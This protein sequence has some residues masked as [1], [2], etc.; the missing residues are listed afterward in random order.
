MF[1]NYFIIKGTPENASYPLVQ[2]D[3]LS[4]P[5]PGEATSGAVLYSCTKERMGEKGHYQSN[6]TNN[7]A[8]YRGLL[9]G[10]EL[11]IRH[12]IQEVL[13]E[14]DSQLV[15]MQVAKKWK[16]KN[17]ELQVI[18]DKIQELIQAHFQFV[19]IRHIP[20]EQNNYAD[21]ITNRV[22]QQKQSYEWPEQ[23]IS[24]PVIVHVEEKKMEK[25][26][27]IPTVVGD[28]TLHQEVQILKQDML[29]LKTD[30]REILRLIHLVYDF[31]TQ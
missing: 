3:G 15:V 22:F 20:R 24:R 16:V 7:Q 23:T 11:C 18:Y 12:G 2:F 13:I 17:T 4:V 6:G 8:E 21:S 26:L 29:T 1:S 5:N 9:L 10:L 30:V 19:A 14:G 28:N 31:E 25:S 27:D